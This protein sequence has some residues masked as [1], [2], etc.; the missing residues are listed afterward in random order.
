MDPLSLEPITVGRID[1]T[2]IA[3]YL[4]VIV[5][6]GVYLTR[7]ASR[8]IDSYFLGGRNMP[9]WLLGLSGTASYFDVTG[10]M[11]TIAF[12]YIM[13]QR[14]L[15]IQ[16]EWGFITMAC[17]AAF[18]GKWLRRSNVMTGA[19]WMVIRFG[20]GPAGQFARTAYAVMA[21]VVAVAF[22]GFAEY[23]C[24]Q[25]FH[26]FVPQFRPTRWPSR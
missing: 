12:F 6:A 2:V 4:V 20:D 18:M 14:F 8:N 9:W 26:V 1:L 19:E 17:F 11:W 16:W 24:G 5:L 10:V 21:V 15:W 3:V 7:L 13:G 25:F 23:G 22:I